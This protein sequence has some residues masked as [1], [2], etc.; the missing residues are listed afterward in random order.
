MPH[1][2][3]TS[4]ELPFQGAR[5]FAFG[6]QHKRIVDLVVSFLVLLLAAPGMILIA[7]LIKVTDPGPVL[8][9]QVRVGLNGRQFRCLKFRTMAVDADRIFAD[10]LQRNPAAR[11][12]WE[13]K[14]KLADDPRVTR[15]GR[16]LRRTSLD[17]LPQIFNVLAGDMS[18]VGPRPILAAEMARYGDKLGLYLSVRPG[19]TGLWQVSGRSQCSYPERVELDAR[20]VIEWRLTTDLLILLRTVPAVVRQRGSC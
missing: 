5:T 1:D 14:Q 18:L 19:L 15:L 7:L 17:E 3:Q 11:E 6:Q 20:Y 2:V 9:K 16:W 13:Q 8:F 12:E 4:Q 10:H